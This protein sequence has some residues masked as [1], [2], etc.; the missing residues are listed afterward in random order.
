MVKER[1]SGMTKAQYKKLATDSA[2]H[3][4][5]NIDTDTV[6]DAVEKALV[7]WKK[8]VHKQIAEMAG[9]LFSTMREE[10]RPF[11]VFPQGGEVWF[12]IWFFG[13]DDDEK[14]TYD[15]AEVFEEECMTCNSSYLELRAVDATLARMKVARDKLLERVETEGGEVDGEYIKGIPPDGRPRIVVGDDGQA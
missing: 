2:L 4:V 14:K 12:Q 15:L 11:I 6:E 9:D 8:E 1:F 5:E 3:W 13:D 7:K 10:A